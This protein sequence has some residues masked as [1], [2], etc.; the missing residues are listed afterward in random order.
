LHGIPLG[1]RF[2]R[3]PRITVIQGKKR[4]NQ[5]KVPPTPLELTHRILLTGEAAV[6]IGGELDLDTAEQAFRYVQRVINGHRGPVVVSL[7]GV[8]FC[9]ARGLRAL[10]R[11]ANYADQANRPFRVTGASPR[12]TKL[13]HMTGLD[14]KFPAAG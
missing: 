10:V 9:D 12:L 5:E 7:A 6:E 3:G 4:V 11:M 8:S 14:S 13:M 2:L 1:G